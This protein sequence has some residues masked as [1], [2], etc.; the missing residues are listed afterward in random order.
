[1]EIAIKKLFAQ[2][3][4]W[5]YDF[6][7]AAF[8]CFQVLCGLNDVE[9]SDGTSTSLIEVFLEHETVTQVFICVLL[10]SIAVAALCTAASIVKAVV[11]MRGGE[12]KSHAKSLGQGL[13][14]ILITLA[15][16]VILLSF[17]GVSNTALSAINTAFGN[18]S[19][20]VTFSAMLFDLSVESGYEIDEE[21]G[22][23]SYVY[24][25]DEDGNPVKKPEYD[26]DGNVVYNEDGS[27][28][29][30]S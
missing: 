9:L 19:D 12:R 24:V 22:T 1:M 17:I 16:A 4:F 26:D 15:M 11:N 25:Y 14:A 18:D 7:D 27:M 2:L 23:I 5:L 3:L 21:N 28:R 10:V 8:E 20:S 13:G 30:T 6:I 29:T